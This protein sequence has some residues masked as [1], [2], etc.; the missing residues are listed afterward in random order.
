VTRESQAP[1][2][3]RLLRKYG[4]KL[5]SFIARH[6]SEGTGVSNDYAR[7]I[8]QRAGPNV[9]ALREIR[10]PRNEQFLYLEEHYQSESFWRSLLEAFDASGSVYGLAVNSLIARQ[11]IVPLAQFGIMSGSPSRLIGHLSYEVVLKRLS[12]IGLLD[13]IDSA[14][15][16]PCITFGEHSP[17]ATGDLPLLKAQAV[18]EQIVL[19]ALREWV[20]KLG[21]GSYGKVALRSGKDQPK[22]GQFSWDLTAPTYLHPFV[23]HLEG[24]RPSPG[25]FVADVLLGD[26]LTQQQ[27]R[28]FLNKVTI[29]RRQ[30]KMR[31]F[32]AVLVANYF[33]AEAF[34]L[35][36]NQGVIFA[37]PD[38]LFGIGIS[39]ALRQLIQILKNAAAVAVKNPHAIEDL[40]S[41]LG[42]LEGAALNLRG[43]LFEMILAYCFRREGIVDIGVPVRD[44]ETGQPAEIDVL[45]KGSTIVR[46]CEC[47]GYGTNM[48]DVDDVEGWLERQVPRIRKYL[49]NN[50]NYR[51]LPLQFEYWTAGGFTSSAVAYLKA[52]RRASQKYAI[53]WKDGHA[54]R[55]YVNELK[56]SYIIKIL[57]E[58]YF[59]HPLSRPVAAM[60][61]A[62]KPTLLPVST[63]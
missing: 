31:P 33:S 18:A 24:S 2:V 42:S 5:S 22:F 16:G 52:K 35:G 56:E 11:G 34:Q 57:D 26:N 8:I 12:D 50:D 15:W 61:S 19:D 55:Q 25:F 63:A 29:L 51:K 10:F 58:Q 41:K 30:R 20:R 49:L 1:S 46:A 44:P 9:L 4:P 45:V 47:K 23:R 6:L 28:Y 60:I 13:V 54:L 37:T 62:P 17:F 36:R 32:L 39:A 59:R 27:V 43:P 7:K 14:T 3:E 21:F 38:V 53:V 40:F 48:V